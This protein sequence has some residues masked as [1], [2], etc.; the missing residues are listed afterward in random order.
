VRHRESAPSEERPAAYRPVAELVTDL[1]R[2]V[3]QPHVLGQSTE[4]RSVVYDG[5]AI[6][7]GDHRRQSERVED[8]QS[9]RVVLHFVRSCEQRVGVEEH[10]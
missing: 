4:R 6:G 1:A 8:R 2:S 9:L 5:L 7:V 3:E 10:A